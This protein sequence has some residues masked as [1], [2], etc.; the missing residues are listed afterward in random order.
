MYV[1]VHLTLAC[2]TILSIASSSI[3]SVMMVGM[4]DAASSTSDDKRFL[5]SASLVADLPQ[6]AITIG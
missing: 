4:V 6:G 2:D 3:L 5:S 1:G